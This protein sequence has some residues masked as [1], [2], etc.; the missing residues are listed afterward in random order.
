MRKF[1]SQIINLLISAG[2]IILA[3]YILS[4][5]N[6]RLDLT[7]EK[8]YT[9]SP[10]SR[11]I[12]RDLS[13][14]VFI[15]VYLDGDLPP[16]FQRLSNE[17][18]DLLN[19]F[20]TYADD[21]IQYQFINPD[22]IEDKEA[23]E[24]LYADLYNK[25]LQPTN[26]Q[27]NEAGGGQSQK[28]IFPG[29][30]IIHN[31]IELP[32]NLL[33]NNPGLGAEQNLNNSIQ[34]LE[35]KFINN[36]YNLTTDTL[37]KIAFLEGHGE[38]DQYQTGDITRELANFYQVDRGKIG[39]MYGSLD[40][41]AAVVVAKPTQPFPEED[42][43]VLDQ[44]LMN[45]GRILWFIDVVDVRMD[46][47]QKGATM[48]LIRDLNLNDQLFK[49]GVRINPNLIQDVQCALIPVNT[50]LAG[51]SAKFTP[52]PWLYFPLLNP[53]DR[54]PL[55]KDISLV[56]AEFVSS[57]DTLG[58]DPEVNKV[59]LL[60]SSEMSKTVSAP[61][62]ITLEEVT[63]N[64]P[65]T[66]FNAPYLPTAVLIEGALKSVFQNR[67]LDALPVKGEYTYREEAEDAKILVVSDGDII[68]NEVQYTPNGPAINPL[69]YDRFSQQ[70]FGNKEFI[71]N[72]VNYMTG[73]EGIMKLRA[74]EFKLRLLDKGKIR[75]ERL[76]WQLVNTAGPVIIIL[77]FGLLAGFYRK[78]RYKK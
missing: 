56:R 52:A 78:Y 77:I 9:L 60:R 57:I 75:E 42:K 6:I 64:I 58:G 10:V 37:K 1:S 68:R 51:N 35:Y 29:A 73:N 71:L 22:A 14:A 31:G 34:A 18:E 48:A 72:A 19:D 2:I 12:L 65:R 67:L 44:Y 33:S 20:R 38:L 45:G 50:A 23:R 39:G 61:T 25:G 24:A 13:D 69:G 5:F 15:R 40:E 30:L 47:L 63:Q 21:N 17:T 49:Y 76:T 62:I 55:V 32:V 43:F 26:L 59:I 66:A 70:T 8:R 3:G 4:F 27:M 53:T 41:Y 16:G 7:A 28:I 11:D 36:I 74:K 54:S 46:S